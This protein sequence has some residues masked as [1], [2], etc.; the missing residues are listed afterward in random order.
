LALEKSKIA[1]VV[2]FCENLTVC[3]IYKEQLKDALMF[4]GKDAGELNALL[5]HFK[6]LYSGIILTTSAYCKG[7]D[8][9]FTVP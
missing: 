8:F 3:Q 1:P 5:E 4:C 7:A 2:I 9:V 6:S